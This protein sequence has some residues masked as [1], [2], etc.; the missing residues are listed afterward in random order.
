MPYYCTVSLQMKKL[1][2][3]YVKTLEIVFKAKENLSQKKHATVQCDTG[4]H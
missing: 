3:F 2:T 1:V 4:I